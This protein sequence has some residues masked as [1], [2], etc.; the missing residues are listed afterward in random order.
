MGVDSGLPDF[1][2]NEGFWKAYPP[3]RKLGYPFMEMASP[4]RFI[5]APELGWGFYGHRLGL[6]RETRPHSG[7]THLLEFAQTG[8]R[9]AFVFTSNVDGHFQHAG[10][11]EDRLLE[12]HG[13]IHHLQCLENCTDRLWS[14]ANEQVEVDPATM[15]AQAPLPRCPD[16]GGL[17]RPNILMFGDWNW[18]GRRT[19]AQEARFRTWMENLEDASATVILEFG[20]G[21]AVPTVRHLSETVARQTGGT[22]IR[23]NPREPHVPGDIHAHGLPLR[24]REAIERLL[25]NLA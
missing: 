1:R 12:C 6:Y 24:A 21:S 3:Y 22:L 5:D 16:C 25:G 8:S 17:A 11:P 18:N 13:S 14:A 19:Q 15:R 2:G 9:P 10:F 4:Q 7:F 20:A 23:V